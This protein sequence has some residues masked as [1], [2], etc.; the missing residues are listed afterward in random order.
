MITK[1][2]SFKTESILSDTVDT[3]SNITTIPPDE[4]TNTNTHF[5]YTSPVGS[6]L[7]HE[8]I[9]DHETQLALREKWKNLT[10]TD[11]FLFE[12]VMRNKRVY[13]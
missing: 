2:F 9:I 12:K 5:S 10:I 13:A 3:T 6:L 4:A 8:D 11:N 7:V 1:Q